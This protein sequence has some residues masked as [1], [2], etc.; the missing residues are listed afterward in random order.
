[1]ASQYCPECGYELP[2]GARFCM[3]C[4]ASLAGD[5]T[6]ASAQEAAREAA[7]VQRPQGTGTDWTAIATA[8]VAF[9]GL[10]HLSRGARNTFV[11]VAFLFLFF[12]CPLICGFVVFAMEWLARLFGF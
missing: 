4:G 5:L 12:G 1:V 11:L 3:D 10:R 7:P 8:I 2:A 6:P 9:F